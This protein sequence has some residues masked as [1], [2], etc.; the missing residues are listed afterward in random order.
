MHEL[1]QTYFEWLEKQYPA[2]PQHYQKKGN[3][4]YGEVNYYS[5]CRIIEYLKLTKTDVF[6]DIGSGL[7]LA[8][9]Q[10]FFT[11]PIQKAIGI[12]VD[13]HRCQQAKERYQ[14]LI[15]DMPVMFTERSLLLQ[16][17]NFL[18][19]FFP[20]VTVAYTCSSAFDGPLLRA[21]TQQLNSYPKLKT[22]ASLRKLE[23]LDGF[24]LVKVLP[25]E[26]SWDTVNC[27]I[28]HKPI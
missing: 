24:R 23:G 28:Y 1:V 14:Q 13:T 11:T 10:V 4:M 16:E 15:R 18:T 3:A 19:H 12:E 9:F 17:G 8:L 6:L 22:V 2:D 25:V 20:E 21:L 5:F 27:F 26:C 7:G